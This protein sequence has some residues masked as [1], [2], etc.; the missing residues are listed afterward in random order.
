MKDLKKE[1]T[2]ELRY[3]NV[4]NHI[5]DALVQENFIRT[6]LY[7]WIP[8][9]N[10]T[11]QYAKLID[12]TEWKNYDIIHVNLSA[13]DYH[14]LG[15]IRDK[16]GWDSKTKIVAN[17]DYTCELWKG[18]FAFPDEMRKQL[19]NADMIFGTEPYMAGALAEIAQRKVYVM[20]HPCFVKRLK[21]MKPDRKEKYLGILWH[22]YDSN[23]FVPAL[24]ARNHGLVTHLLGYDQAHDGRQFSTEILYQY[25]SKYTSFLEYCKQ[26][27]RADLVYDPFT[28]TSYGRSAIDAAALGIPLVGSDTVWSVKKCFPYTCCNVWDVKK[29]RELIDRVIN[30]KDFRKKV[31]DTAQKNV[32][33]YSNERCKKRFL[34]ALK[35][36]ENRV[37]KPQVIDLG[38]I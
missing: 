15:M 13:Q 14:L 30:D 1:D 2:K 8:T 35:D 33:F 38:D 22:R 37:N 26:M 16:I 5:H 10:G 19:Q 27:L 4:T 12:D 24:A 34:H 23:T 36:S 6:G 29:S 3:L 20:P 25:V 21:S 9:F 32:E 18:V 11:V 28:Y 7:Q 17:N 31:I